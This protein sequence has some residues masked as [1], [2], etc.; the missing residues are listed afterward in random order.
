M[1]IRFNIGG[2][3]QNNEPSGASKGKMFFILGIAG[4]MGVLIMFNGGITVTQSK[5][6]TSYNVGDC[7]KGS[8]QFYD[9]VSCNNDSASYKIIDTAFD[10]NSTCRWG[11]ELLEIRTNRFYCVESLSLI[12]INIGG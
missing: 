1:K 8:N 10:E 5:L 6:E 7:V 4:L 3:N 2:G 12:D 11:S 9:K